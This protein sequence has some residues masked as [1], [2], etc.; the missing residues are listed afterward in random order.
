MQQKIYVFIL[1]KLVSNFLLSMLRKET[2]I[3]QPILRKFNAAVTS[4][5]TCSHA[6]LNSVHE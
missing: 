1:V 6:Y 3:L 2:E 5:R 4:M